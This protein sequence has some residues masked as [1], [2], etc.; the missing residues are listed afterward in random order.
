M[1][2]MNPAYA[3]AP[4]QGP[5]KDNPATSTSNYPS[6]LAALDAQLSALLGGDEK[7]A[8]TLKSYGMAA[9]T[10]TGAGAPADPSFNGLDYQL[11]LQ[12]MCYLQAQNNYTLCS[13]NLFRWQM[14]EQELRQRREWAATT[15][16][17]VGGG[18]PPYGPLMGGFGGPVLLHHCLPAQLSPGANEAGMPAPLTP[19]TAQPMGTMGTGVAPVATNFMGPPPPAT[20]TA[21]TPKVRTFSNAWTATLP[22]LRP[23]DEQQRKRSKSSAL[24]EF[25]ASSSVAGNPGSEQ[26]TPLSVSGSGHSIDLA[27][28]SADHV[29]FRKREGDGSLS[30]CAGSEFFAAGLRQRKQQSKQH[31]KKAAGRTDEESGGFDSGTLGGG[32]NFSEWKSHPEMLNQ[33]D[34]RAD[35]RFPSSGAHQQHLQATDPGNENFAGFDINEEHERLRNGNGPSTHGPRVNATPNAAAAEEKNNLPLN[36]Q[37]LK[38]NSAYHKE[39]ETKKKRGV[40][41]TRKER[42][43]L[44]Q[45]TEMKEKNKKRWLWRY[46]IGFVLKVGLILILLE[47]K[48]GWF[49]LYGLMVV[50]FLFGWLDWAFPRGMVEGARD[51]GGAGVGENLGAD[52]ENVAAGFSD[53]DDSEEETS[54][55]DS[56]G[57]EATDEDDEGGSS[58]KQKNDENHTSE[59]AP[60]TEIVMEKSAEKRKK[61]KKKKSANDNSAAQDRARARP[62]RARLPFPVIGDQLLVL[63]SLQSKYEMDLAK[64]RERQAKRKGLLAA[65]EEIPEHLN[66]EHDEL[67]SRPRKWADIKKAILEAEDVKKTGACSAPV[68]GNRGLEAETGPVQA[69]DGGEAAASHESGASSSEEKK[70]E[71]SPPDENQ[72]N[73]TKDKIN[74]KDPYLIEIESGFKTWCAVFFDQLVICFVMTLYPSYAPNPRRLQLYL[75]GH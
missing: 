69:A 13:L 51:N 75:P 73:N 65:G 50:F 67:P 57:A 71:T 1:V 32:N 19:A 39:L 58:A 26:A 7:L 18:V 4:P 54:S 36:E 47:V 60:A 74:P 53:D 28:F 12:S 14:I 70:D 10:T 22:R 35:N 59:D 20:A 42:A 40:R 2:A 30:P 33:S 16:S 66:E 21:S 3:A 55:S 68:G 8:A 64:V 15:T 25:A 23:C 29:P 72:A 24:S 49:L 27:A 17:S 31:S 44:K 56:D 11:M 45:L 61:K 9:T 6:D 37:P 46:R 52:N 34:V 43:D 38:L 5:G 63:A 48:L 62:A 41:L